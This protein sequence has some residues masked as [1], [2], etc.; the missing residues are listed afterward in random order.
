[1]TVGA[2]LVPPAPVWGAV[3]ARAS[4]LAVEAARVESR[5]AR[6]ESMGQGSLRAPPRG[7]GGCRKLTVWTR[8]R[9]VVFV[10]RLTSP[11]RGKRSP[12]PPARRGKTPVSSPARRAAR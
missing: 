10:S 1:N 8:R 2:A 12:R 6:R 9:E 4:V 3:C 7:G 11:A 5:N